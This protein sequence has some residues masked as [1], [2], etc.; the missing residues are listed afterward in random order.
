MVRPALRS[1]A[2]NRKRIRTPGNRDVVHFWRGKPKKAH[3]S[4]CKKPLQ[5]IP[6]LRDAKFRKTPHTAR[7]ANRM[8]SGRYCAKCLQNLIRESVRSVKSE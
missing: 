6:R 5:A 4:L 3:C 2:Q 7:R 8:E 1:H